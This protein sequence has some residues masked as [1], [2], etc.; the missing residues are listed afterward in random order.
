MIILIGGFR[1]DVAV[2]GETVR[3]ARRRRIQ[4]RWGG[5]NDGVM[6]QS[7]E[8]GSF[9]FFTGAG[10]LD[11]GFEDAGVAPLM[12]N[13]IDKNFSPVY[14]YAHEQMK[15]AIAKIRVADRKRVC[16]S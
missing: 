14:L 2:G 13:E 1:A 5:M 8:F 12:A 16:I 11:L 9:S 6:K 3:R 4:E 10:F 15:T 7:G